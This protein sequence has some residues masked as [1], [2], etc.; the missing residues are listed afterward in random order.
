[1]RNDLLHVVKSR[2]YPS[3]ECFDKKVAKVGEGEREKEKVA[4]KGWKRVWRWR[5][6]GQVTLEMLKGGGSKE[7]VCEL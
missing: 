1:V 6:R 5:G 7:R 2:R 4:G 3:D